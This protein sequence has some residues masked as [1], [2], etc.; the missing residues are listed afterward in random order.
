MALSS[1]MDS[2]LA[3]FRPGQ[4]TVKAGHDDAVKRIADRI[5]LDFRTRRSVCRNALVA[6]AAARGVVD[7]SSGADW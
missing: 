1:L 5:R 2:Y 6:A 7:S 3:D 4:A